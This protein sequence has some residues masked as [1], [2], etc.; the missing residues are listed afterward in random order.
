MSTEKTALLDGKNS[1]YSSQSEDEGFYLFV[2][3]FF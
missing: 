3:F 1:F 2:S